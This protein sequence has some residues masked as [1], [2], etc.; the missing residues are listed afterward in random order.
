M[1]VSE[2]PV[3][4]GPLYHASART[5][6]LRVP[7]RLFRPLAC[8]FVDAACLVVSGPVPYLFAVVKVSRTHF[9]AGLSEPF[10]IAGWNTVDSLSGCPQ[11][12]VPVA[13][14]ERLRFSCHLSTWISGRS[15]QAGGCLEASPWSFH[16]PRGASLGASLGNEHG[17]LTP[18]IRDRFPVQSLPG[19]AT[20]PAALMPAIA[21]ASSLSEV[22]P[23][24]PTEPTTSPPAVRIRTP[25]GTGMNGPPTACGNAPTK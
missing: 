13:L 23:E 14:F 5:D 12:T 1:G 25:P 11:T 21:A 22:S 3:A 24:I 16:V 10:P 4:S 18:T 2:F 8:Y 7:S 17:R 9:R 6:A 15:F 20:R 19:S